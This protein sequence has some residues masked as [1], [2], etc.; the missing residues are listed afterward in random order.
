[1][2]IRFGSARLARLFSS[3]RDLVRIYGAPRA[4]R[5]RARML[6][7]EAAPALSRVP[8]TLPERRHQLTGDRDEQYAV[9]ID[10]QIRLVFESGDDPVPRLPDG[11]IDVDRV[12]SIVILEVI[13]YH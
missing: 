4:A 12:T 13:D 10:N 9:N 8:V 3:E 5:I 2:E 1:M 11:G 7:L 6:V